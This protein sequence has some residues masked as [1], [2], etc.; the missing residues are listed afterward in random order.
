MKESEWFDLLKNPQGR[1]VRVLP[2]L[3]KHVSQLGSVDDSY[4]KGQIVLLTSLDGWEE[5]LTARRLAGEQR[6]D[7]FY[8]STFAT[9]SSAGGSDCA[10]FTA[11]LDGRLARIGLTIHDIELIG[12][13]EE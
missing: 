5:Q 4:P 9:A 11:I 8:T 7:E 10:F 13:A 1:L 12:P 2:R 3:F 6:P